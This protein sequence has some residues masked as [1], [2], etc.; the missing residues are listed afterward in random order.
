MDKRDGQS[1]IP[2]AGVS[3]R[4]NTVRAL[5]GWAGL[6]IGQDIALLVAAA[7]LTDGYQLPEATWLYRQHAAQ[8][9]RGH[10]R[11]QWADRARQITLQR[12]AAL[13]LAAATLTG[14]GH[15]PSPPRDVTPAMKT[16]AELPLGE[17]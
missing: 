1:P 15:D 10:D 6:P 12:I 14:T 9:S 3:Y 11:D 7:E 8:I 4:T 13:R 2:C 16:A 17:D 5:G